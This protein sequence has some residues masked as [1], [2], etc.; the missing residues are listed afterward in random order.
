VDFKLIGVARDIRDQNRK[1]VLGFGFFVR[2]LVVDL[3]HLESVPL[4]VNEYL[5][6]VDSD[7]SIE[8][9]HFGE[10]FLVFFKFYKPVP[11]EFIGFQV[12]W[13]SDA[14]NIF[15]FIV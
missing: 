9:E 8:F 5:L 11:F 4:I 10:Y 1:L 13:E 7:Q 15:D 2:L 6:V 12:E 14:V 3:H